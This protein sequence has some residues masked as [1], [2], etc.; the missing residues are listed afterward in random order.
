MSTSTIFLDDNILSYLRHFSMREPSRFKRCRHDTSELPMG[1]MQIAPE[2][3]QF[4]HMLLQVMGARRA[5]EIGSFTGYSGL[6]LASALPEDGCLVACEVNEKWASQAR[7]CWEDAGLMK[8][9]ELH[10]EPAR[11]TLERLLQRDAQNTF[12]FIFIDADK[13]PLDHYYE[14]ALKLVRPGGLVA[15]DNVLW[16]GKVADSSVHDPDTTAIRAL[17]EKIHSDERIDLSVVP[18]GDGMALC[19][20]RS[21]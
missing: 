7:H 1:S 2:Q 9:I 21:T 6:W 3:G 11:E 12:D 5:L 17:N 8:R 14:A 13:E 18:I 20:K 19:R 15:V 4:L 16:G 10:V